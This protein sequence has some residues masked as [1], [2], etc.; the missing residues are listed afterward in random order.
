VKLA[1]HAK[2]KQ[3]TKENLDQ[4]ACTIL[5][6]DKKIKALKGQ[7]LKDQLKVYQFAGAPNL[8]QMKQATR[9]NDI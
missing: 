6:L 1:K 2:Q 7:A 9:V 4:L 3:K 8:Q 5:I